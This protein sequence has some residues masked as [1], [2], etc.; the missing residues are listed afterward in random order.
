MKDRK[1]ALRYARALLAAMPD[2]SEAEGASQFLD[3]VREGMEATPMFR[4]MMV[5][6]AVT[7]SRRQA[8][9]GELAERAGA[10]TILR[11]FLSTL[12]DNNRTGE[13]PAIAEVFQA[14]LER[15]TGIVPAQVTTATAMDPELA[16]RTRAVLEKVTGKN[17]RLAFDV[18]PRL[19]GGA[20]TRVGSMVYDGS[21]RTQLTRLR[22]EMTQ[23]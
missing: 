19:I 17:V 21:V 10:P 8:I 9:L 12:V 20:I 15:R 11:N 16:E 22:R 18:D 13:I 7:R 1:L 4:E 3:A 23:E 14:E 6:P 5:D 2:Q